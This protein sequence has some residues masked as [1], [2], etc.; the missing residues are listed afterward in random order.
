MDWRGEPGFAG[1]G[2]GLIG[3]G[4][5]GGAH[6][7]T[8]EAGFGAEDPGAAGGVGVVFRGFVSGREGLGPGFE[9]LRE[10]REDIAEQA[11]DA[12]RDVDPGASEDGEGKDFETA[13]SGGAVV[14]FRCEAGK[15]EG[16]REFFA[17]RAHGG[18]APKV[19]D[20]AARVVAVV[21]QV[22]ADQFLGQLDALGMGVARRHGAGVDTVEV[23]AGGQDVTAA[24]VGGACGAGGDFVAVQRGEEAF[25][26]AGGL[27]E[28]VQAV[29]EL[30]FLQ[31]ADEAV[32]P[33]DRLGGGGVL[34][35][36]KVGGDAGGC[37]LVADR[38]D[39]AG[40]AGGVE[41]VGS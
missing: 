39:Q 32:D 34:R 40:A 28:D 23:A 33:G 4:I 13:H 29:A 37:G 30:A 22:A 19:D 17:R 24:P 10:G 14:P 11:G 7:Q 35:Q 26:F 15:V 21:L 31:V 16:H 2:A 36:A 18:A 41:A 1:G 38:G 25:G 12:E 5:G 8:V 20:K 27:A 3:E 6:A 9:Q